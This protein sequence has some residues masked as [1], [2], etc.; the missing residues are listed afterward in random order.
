MSSVEVC[1]R[2]VVE[3]QQRLEVSQQCLGLIP[4][5]SLDAISVE[6]R[7]S[8]LEWFSLAPRKVR[9]LTSS[10]LRVHSARQVQPGEDREDGAY[11]LF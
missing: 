2:V 10:S 7:N 5:V 11:T 3:A 1:V 4:L 6:K 8:I 9:L